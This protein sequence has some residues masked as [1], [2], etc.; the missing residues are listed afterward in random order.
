MD[1][2]IVKKIQTKGLSDLLREMP[3]GG[4]VHIPD[5]QFRIQSVYHACYRLRKEG[6]NHVCCAKRNVD[7]CIVTRLK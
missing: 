5:K 4:Q 7:G 3:I 2:I 1:K 6:F